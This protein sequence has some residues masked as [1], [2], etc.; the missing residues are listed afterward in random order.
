[1]AVARCERVR[2]LA[3]KATRYHT[4][5]R[6]A[7][8][9]ANA[10]ADLSRARVSQYGARGRDAD[11]FP[12]VTFSAPGTLFSHIT[13]PATE[14]YILWLGGDVDR[15][16]VARIDGRTV[17]SASDQSGGDGNMIQIGP[18]V[19]GFENQL[20]RIDQIVVSF[21]EGLGMH[22]S[23][24]REPTPPPSGLAFAGGYPVPR[25]RHRARRPAEG[26]H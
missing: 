4:V 5:L 19:S 7:V 25:S 15:P 13:V 21:S 1:M 22:P 18:V 6:Y 2:A 14:T 16:F 26:L 3:A 17:G 9:P 8:R 20:S 12:M 24:I 11:G 23:R 10:I